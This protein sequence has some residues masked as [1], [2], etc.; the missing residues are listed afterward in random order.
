[1]FK[2]F[3]YKIRLLVSIF[4]PYKKYAYV[5]LFIMIVAALSEAV[6]LGLIIPFVGTVLGD[7]AYTENIKVVSYFNQFF[8]QL[9]P[10]N[11]RLIGISIFI[12]ITF[13][14][15]N[16][17]IYLSSVL[18]VHFKNSLRK[19]WSSKIMERYIHCEYDH[20]IS[21]KRG[22]LINNLINE[23]MVASKF[24]GQLAQY[25]L[26][27]ILALSIYLIMLITN[28]QVTLL[29][30][31][32]LVLILGF[33]WKASTRF[34][35]SSG[36]KRLAL[37][38][39][40][41]AEGEQSLNGIRQV[42]LFSL[43]DNVNKSFAK[44]FDKLRKILT[45]LGIYQSLPGP[46]GET[47]IILCLVLA[48]IYFE[49]IGSIPLVAVMPM[50][51]F[52]ATTTQRLYRHIAQVLS[53]RMLM[54]SYIPALKL[55]HTLIYEE[56][57]KKEDLIHGIAVNQLSG[58]IVFND[59]DFSYE[60]SSPLFKGLNL[61][62]PKNKITAVV[63]RSGSGKSSL[64]DLLCGLYKGYKGKILIGDMELRTVNLASWRKK[65]GF[66]SQDTFLFN[67]TVRENILLGKQD[68]S[69]NEIK[70]AARTAYAHD[71]IRSLPK[72]YD[73]VLGDRGQ[74]L[75]G[76]QRQ[77]ITVARALIRSPELLIFDEATSALDSE[78]E[79]LIQQSIEDLS[80]QKTIIIIAH[81]IS[82]IKNA[83]VI[84]VMDEGHIVESGTYEE[85]MDKRGLFRS[86]VNQ[87]AG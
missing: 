8:A 77:R 1:M 46:L 5:L 29:L 61:R 71:F 3:L 86:M 64:V 70:T 17:F 76:G 79:K 2:K 15:K 33:F 82:T 48:I 6:G 43:E 51:A 58:D 63:G 52:L 40:I 7:S 72:D 55:V 69:E 13:L 35:I 59:V 20:I 75:S 83:D 25:I 54:L 38:Q 19:F 73:T 41:S 60:D 50:L 80:E 24:I 34:S 22:T 11:Q 49:Y 10:E 16:I 66:V 4:G 47:L 21:Q 32:A 28:W 81:R 37:N 30:T 67:E 78:S 68:A 56:E 62:I 18:S 44:K 42:R 14:F 74:K 39:E 53:D 31:L 36:K 57:F 65:I 85:L 23:P 9:F 12:F 26:R 87:Q 45:R 84:Y 27:I